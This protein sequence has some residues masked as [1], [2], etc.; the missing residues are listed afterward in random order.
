M[1]IER[2]LYKLLSPLRL[3]GAGGE[4]EGSSSPF[5]RDASPVSALGLGGG[6]W[7]GGHAGSLSETMRSNWLSIDH[8]TPQDFAAKGRERGS[9]GGCQE[10][11]VVHGEGRER[12]GAGEGRGGGGGHALGGGGDAGASRRL[13]LVAGRGSVWTGLYGRQDEEV[14]APIRSRYSMLTC[15]DMC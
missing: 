5:S 15:A 2:E 14:S 13:R 1:Y 7:R 9:G 6:G 10:W 12:A 8:E 3:G 11:D 4:G